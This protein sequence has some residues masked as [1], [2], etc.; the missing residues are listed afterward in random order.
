MLPHAFAIYISILVCFFF[1]GSIS[2]GPAVHNEV[3]E[4]AL[5]WFQALSDNEHDIYFAKIISSNINSLQTGVLF[6]DWGYGC[7]GYDSESEAAHWSPFLEAAISLLNSQYQP[8]YDDEAQKIISFLYGIA[9]HQ[10]ADESWHSINMK[11]GFMNVV[12]ELEFNNKESSHS[13]L[14]VGGDFFMKTLNN[15][16]YIRVNL[17]S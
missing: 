17:Q 9:S 16:D 2:C 11:D 15:L 12:D 13:I 4:R 5:N 14:D 3:S 8:P 7:L 10:V 1:K 6:P